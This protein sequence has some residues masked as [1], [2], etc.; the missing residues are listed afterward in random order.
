[1]SRNT[2]IEYAT[3]QL[4]SK[5]GIKHAEINMPEIGQ[6]PLRL[7]MLQYNQIDASFLP[8]PAASIAMNSKHRSLVST[9]ELGIDFTA[10]AF[11]E[12]RSTRREKKSSYSSQDITWE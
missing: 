5:A 10:T 3:D 4:L 12:K 1:M 8:D 11:H 9:Q 2:V 7:Q 6:L